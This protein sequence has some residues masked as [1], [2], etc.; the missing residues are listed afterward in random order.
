VPEEV[1]GP[2]VRPAPESTLLTVPGLFLS[3]ASEIVPLAMSVPLTW[4]LRRS[5]ERTWLFLM[6]LDP[7]VL[8]PGSACA[9]PLIAKQNRAT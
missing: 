8:V 6:S 4:P 9:A 1:I 3:F 5:T 7:T 2:P